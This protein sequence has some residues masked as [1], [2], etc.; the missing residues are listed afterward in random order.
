MSPV[1]IVEDILVGH[2][3]VDEIAAGRVQH[4]LR[5]AGR[6][7]GIED[8]ERILSS[9]S[10]PAGNRPFCRCDGLRGTRCRVP[11]PR[12]RQPP[13]RL[14]TRNTVTLTPFLLGDFDC[15]LSVLALSGIDCD[16]HAMPSSAVMTKVE[17]QS[18]MRPARASGEKPPKTIGV[19]GADAGAGQHGVG[20]LGYHRHVDGDPVALLRRRASFIDVGKPAKPCSVQPRGR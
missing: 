18:T 2:G 3:G 7:G 13:V 17:S 10:L 19:N 12:Q 14:T 8:E 15:A 11:R 5:F 6:A 16:R 4:A 1:V 20:R 9:S